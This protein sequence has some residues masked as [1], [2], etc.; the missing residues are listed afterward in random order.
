MYVQDPQQQQQQQP[1]QMAPP[2]SERVV[3]V[4]ST[5]IQQP[6]APQQTERVVY[7]S[8]NEQPERVVYVAPPNSQQQPLPQQTER[9]VYV[10]TANNQQQVVP[11]QP[12]VEHIVYVTADQLQQPMQQHIVRQQIHPQQTERIVYVTTQQQSPPQ[13]TERIVYVAAGDSPLAHPAD[14]Q[15]EMGGFVPDHA[16]TTERIVYVTTEPQ[17]TFQTGPRDRV[18]YTIPD[19]SPRVSD[20]VTF[21]SQPA[22]PNLVA[23]N[24]LGVAPATTQYVLQETE[25]VEM[26]DPTHQVAP[27]PPP[28]TPP[29]TIFSS[30]P[31]MY[32]FKKKFRF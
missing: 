24:G 14:F 32:H 27:S 30:C 26:V 2:Q 9:V 8:A 23:S 12:Q 29:W 19:Q 15:H 20:R 3:Y 10:T 25:Y 28:P 11:P 1:Q 4:A 17:A 6:I 16:Q 31:K 5:N 21:I 22:P 18:V 13:Q 7:V